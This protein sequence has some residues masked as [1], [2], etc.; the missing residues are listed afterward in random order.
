MDSKG[1]ITARSPEK[2]RLRDI[3]CRTGKYKNYNIVVQV[4]DGSLQR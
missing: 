1:V 3:D 4:S 2:A